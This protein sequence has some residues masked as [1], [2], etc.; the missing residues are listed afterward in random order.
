MKTETTSRFTFTPVTIV[1]SSKQ[2]KT[3]TGEN[4]LKTDPLL[5]GGLAG[6]ITAPICVETSQRNKKTKKWRNGPAGEIA[7]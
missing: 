2:M 6:V 3:D 5:V 4:V 7:C 1:S